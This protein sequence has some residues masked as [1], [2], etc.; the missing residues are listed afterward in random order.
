VSLRRAELRPDPDAVRE[1]QRRSRDRARERRKERPPRRQRRRKARV[2]LEVRGRA[3]RR[4]RGRCVRP[5][6]GARAAHLHHVL[7]E[8]LFPE[9]AEVEENLVG[10]CMRCNLNHH[11]KPGGRL[12]RAALPACALRLAEAHGPR[13]VAHIERYYPDEGPGPAGPGAETGGRDG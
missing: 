1:W 2:P 12:P 6:C 7:D 13:A 5:G 9:L 11:F 3:L 4:S 8:A 10:M